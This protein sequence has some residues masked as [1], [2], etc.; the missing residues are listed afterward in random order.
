VQGRSTQRARREEPSFAGDPT[1]TLP[2]S[3]PATYRVLRSVMARHRGSL[4]DKR[5]WIKGMDGKEQ[6]EAKKEGGNEGTLGTLRACTAYLTPR[7]HED[8]VVG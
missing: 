1:F 6:G 7:Q 8:F 3:P 4:H 2:P 5:T